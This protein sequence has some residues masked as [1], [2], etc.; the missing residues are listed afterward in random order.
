MTAKTGQTV[1]KS[2]DYMCQGC[3]EMVYLS[4]GDKVPECPCGCNE[5]DEATQTTSSSSKSNSHKS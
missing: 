1:E 5:F 4:K 3:E 2:G